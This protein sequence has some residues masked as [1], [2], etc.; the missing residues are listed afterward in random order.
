MRHFSSATRRTFQPP[1]TELHVAQQAAHD[2][3]ERRVQE[4]ILRQQEEIAPSNPEH[5]SERAVTQWR[6]RVY[7]HAHGERHQG[8]R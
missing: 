4:W 2:P 3:G 7:Y 1:F 8:G 5:P 6:E